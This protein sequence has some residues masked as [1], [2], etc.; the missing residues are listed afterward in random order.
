MNQTTS[1]PLRK[2]AAIMFTDIAGY[3]KAMS[4]DEETALATLRRKRAILRPL[5]IDNNGTFVKEIGDGTLSY[6]PSAIDAAT[7]AVKLQQATFDDLEMNLRV[8]VHIG[9][10]VFD[11]EDV[12]GDGVNVAARLE[13]MAPVGGVCVSKSVFEELLNK[14]EFDGVPL[15]LQQLKGVGRLIDVFALKA[16]NLIHPDPKEYEEHKV[17][18]HTDDEVPSVA[19]LPLKNKGKEEDAFYAYGITADLISDLSRAGRIRVASMDDIEIADAVILSSTDTAKKLNVRYIVTGM[20]WKHEDLFQLSIEMNDTKSNSIVWSDRWQEQWKELTSI[21]GKV[22]DSILRMLN[23]QSPKG[24]SITIG[25]NTHPMAYEFYLRGKY[26][27]QKRQNPEDTK[28]SRELLK[29]AIGLDNKFVLPRVSLGW[30]YAV[31]TE[32]EEGYRI[33]N[34]AFEIAKANDDQE[35]IANTLHHIGLVYHRKGDV[36]GSME[37]LP[38]ALDAYKRLQDR[39]G[40]AE[41]L[42]VMGGNFMMLNELDQARVYT[43]NALEIAKK[44]GNRFNKL[45]CNNSICIILIR[46]KN[47]AEG[48]SLTRDV[49][50][51]ARELG[52]KPIE[53]FSMTRLAW[54][55]LEQDQFQEA[56]DLLERVVIIWQELEIPDI[57]GFTLIDIAEIYAI[58]L[59]DDTKAIQKYRDVIALSQ[60]KGFVD[61]NARGH[62]GLGIIKHKQGKYSEALGYFNTALELWTETEHP[63]R[64]AYTRSWVALSALK[65]GIEA[66]AFAEAQ[67]LDSAFDSAEISGYML[68]EICWNLS[69]VYKAK[70]KPK[71]AAAYL[72]I[73][74][75][76]VMQELEKLGEERERQHYFTENSETSEIISAWESLKNK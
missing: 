51:E 18:P 8:G 68:V 12:F 20:L 38:Q 25:V 63:Q 52:N 47:V 45:I 35:G 1:S 53:A 22:A 4:A 70:E 3:T 40:E 72:Q 14:K 34:E 39:L 58:W 26:R 44:L 11:D 43:E 17:K 33:L 65:S 46:S 76:E 50:N 24:T 66:D 60:K 61:N 2:L 5:I 55:E 69:Q 73:A 67:V 62:F 27:L 7:C 74:Y 15:G 9:D 71:K 10:I 64:M 13:S 56:L 21:K 23:T 42:R 36:K 31:V 19:V 54:Y 28:V 48:I 49:L 57:E 30:S 75:G 37:Y 41:V 59:K 32:Y 29:K 16:K 6:F